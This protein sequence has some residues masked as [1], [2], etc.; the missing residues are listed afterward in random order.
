M[1][2]LELFT[3]SGQQVR[4]VIVDGEP[5]F[6]ATDV[7]AIL[8]LGNVRTSLALLD[9]D[10]KGVRTVDTLG[11]PQ[12]LGVVNEPGLYSLIIRSR[13]AEAKAFK[14]W[15]T[16]DVLPQIRQ[17]GKYAG[18]EQVEYQIP[19]TYAAALELAFLQAKELEEKETL[20]LEAAPKIEAFDA[21]MESDG[22]Y[23]MESAAKIL[24][25]GR[26]TLY[27]RLRDLGIIMRGSTRPYQRY[28]H[29]FDVVAT[30]WTDKYDVVHSD[31]VTKVLPSGL[32]FI[33]QRLSRGVTV[34]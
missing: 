19:K 21:L 20:L 4:T 31:S 24:G 33:R 10:E 27:K 1:S 17:T 29:H 12:S 26:N 25:L 8:D 9:D 11:G 16:H 5:W 30:S 7:A 2:A 28:A 13:K 14:R 23:S 6:V 22:N 15:L 3:Y 32:E 18:A 34:L